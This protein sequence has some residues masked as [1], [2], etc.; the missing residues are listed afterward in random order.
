MK[1][2]KKS[3]MLKHVVKR[4]KHIQRYDER[5]V[6]ASVYA[7]A[8]NCHYHEEPAEKLALTVMKKVNAWSKSKLLIDS[9]D[10]RD[11]IISSLKK[12]D[13]HVALMYKHHLDLC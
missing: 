8:L 5:K 3:K 2:T 1:K 9:R 6:Y 12:Q 4:K 10:I 11:Q 13:K 7:S